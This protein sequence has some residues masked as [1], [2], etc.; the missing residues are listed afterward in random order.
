MI[1]PFLRVASMTE[2]LE[3]LKTFEKLGVESTPIDDALF[4]VLAQNISATE[5]LP[6]FNRSTMDGYAVRSKDTFG[7]TESTPS[8]FHVVGEIRMGEISGIKLK[9]GQT[10]RIWTGGA[11]PEGADAVV[12]VEHAEELD[13]STVELLKAVA[14]FDHVVRKG[15]DFRP[16]EKLLKPG[17]RL[18]PADIGLLAAM[19]IPR[20]SVFK[21]PVVSII[22]SGDEIVPIDQVPPQGC[23]RDINRHTLTAMVAEAHA[24]ALWIGIAPDNLAALSKLLQKALDASDVVIVSGGSSMG[25]RDHVIEAIQARE[26]SQVLLHGVSVSPGKPLIVARIGKQPVIG[27]PGHPVSAMVCFEQFVVT[28]IRR[29]EGEDILQPF[30]RPSVEARLSRNVASKEGRT[31]FVRIRLDY[32]NGGLLAVPVPGKSG[33]ISGMVRAHGFVRIGPD[34][35]GL[36]RGDKVMVNLISDWSEE[37]VEKKHLPGHEA[38]GGSFGDILG[39]AQQEKLSKT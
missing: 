18:R 9:K 21:R 34:C 19:G 3:Q 35:E 17:R 4:R 2:A 29:L 16:G 14:P 28:L 7:S 20:V 36:Y 38:A 24:K 37:S 1:K 30:L 25:S 39:P 23:V 32:D 31:D 10:A 11:L 5:D 6:E 12:M 22:S 27:L 13:N 15:E 8:M 26:D 33:V